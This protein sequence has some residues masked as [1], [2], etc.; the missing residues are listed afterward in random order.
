M[1]EYSFFYN[2]LVESYMLDPITQREIDDV[3]GQRIKHP[4]VDSWHGGNRPAIRSN[5]AGMTGWY[6]GFEV[7]KED[8]KLLYAHRA[9]YFSSITGWAKEFDGSLNVDNGV[10]LVSPAY[11]LSAPF[12]INFH[13]SQPI[14]RDAINAAVSDRCGGHIHLSR[15]N[16]TGKGLYRAIKQWIPLM[17]AIFPKR[18]GNNYC[19]IKKH[20]DM[21]SSGEKHQGVR[22]LD[23]RIEF[24]MPSAVKNTKQLLWRYRLL[25]IL[26]NNPSLS[27]QQIKEAIETDTPLRSLFLEVYTPK[28]LSKRVKLFLMLSSVMNNTPEDKDMAESISLLDREGR[29][30]VR[31]MF[32]ERAPEPVSYL[33]DSYSP[34][35]SA[36]A[37]AYMA[38]NSGFRSASRR[39]NAPEPVNHQEINFDNVIFNDSTTT[40]VTDSGIAEAA[41]VYYRSFIQSPP[42]L[43]PTPNQASD[44][45][46]F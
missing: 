40:P 34:E 6:V 7:E 30:I 23:E 15:S 20:D 10:E 35:P 19:V 24:R 2:R 16:T 4:F 21:C 37:V 9:A 5:M 44:G 31:E 1:K 13:L 17:Y 38:P 3:E 18:I 29:R 28:T 36:S 26:S 42:A 32:D 14:L 45:D 46:H 43:T 22:V 41:A 27:T 11:P 8:K 25:Q 12:W 33:R 39:R